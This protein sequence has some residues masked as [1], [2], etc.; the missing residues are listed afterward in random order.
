MDHVY[1]RIVAE[2]LDEVVTGRI[3][4]GEWL[5]KID[6]I[7]ARHACSPNSAKEAVR[8]LEERHVVEVHAGQGQV[9]LA[10]DRWRVLDRDVAEATLV[11]HDDQR[12]LGEAVEYLRL[13]EISAARLAATKAQSGDVALLSQILDQM[14]AAS[15]GGN[16]RAAHDDRFV[17]AETGFH[18][19]L[20]LLARNR[21]LASA[22]EDLHPAIARV[23]RRRVPE[24][25]SAVIVLHERIVRALE[26]RD[27]TAIAAATDAYGRHLASWLR[28]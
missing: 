13:V 1:Q 7:A 23:R 19:T 9:V 21:F 5:P 26:E 11:R 16:G 20:I 17:E 27:E 28:V 14:R 12:L 22:L 15:G 2:L 10:G 25:D 4:A 6:D 24:R 18:R 8:A 3:A